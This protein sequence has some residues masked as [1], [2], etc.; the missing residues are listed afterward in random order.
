MSINWDNFYSTN[1]RMAL[2][3]MFFEHTTPESRKARPPVFT[4]KPVDRDGLLSIPKLYLASIDEYDA[5]MQIVPNMKQWDNLKSQGWFMNGC[6]KLCFE[7]LKALREHMAQRDAS[8][9]KRILIEKA[10]G[11][12]TGAAKTLLAESKKKAPVG[13]K[14]NKVAPKETATVTRIKQFN[15]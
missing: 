7:G 14:S 4:L 6:E 10:E 15:R 2:K 13:R 8:L 11:G 3:D 9:A 12:D 1:G 5:A